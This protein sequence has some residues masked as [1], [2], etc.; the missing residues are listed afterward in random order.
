MT[1]PFHATV[2]IEASLL[3]LGMKVP[4]KREADDAALAFVRL[5]LRRPPLS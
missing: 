5:H 2:G 4:G 1:H 3:H